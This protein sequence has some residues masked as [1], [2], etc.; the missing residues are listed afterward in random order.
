MPDSRVTASGSTSGSGSR[1]KAKQHLDQFCDARK[2]GE[3]T[4]EVQDGRITRVRKV[5]S[6]KIE[7]GAPS[8]RLRPDVRV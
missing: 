1:A 7:D 4:F 6:V 2:W 5:E 3:V 8:V